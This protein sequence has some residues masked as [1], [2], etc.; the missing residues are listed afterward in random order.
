MD[1]GI[2]VSG[3]ASIAAT[4]SES[5]IAAP[6]TGSQTYV[7]KIVITLE[8]FAATGTISI[9]D[10][11]TAIVGPIL[12]KDGNGNSVV[13]DFGERGYP[14]GANKAV[15]LVNGTAN[16]SARATIVGYKWTT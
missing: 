2:P 6:G 7:Q 14:W 16:V 10:G 11:T 8:S 15:V 13:V 5:I 1:R 3:S 4:G 9:T 12:C